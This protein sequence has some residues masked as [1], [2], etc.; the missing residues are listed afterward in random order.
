LSLTVLQVGRR[1]RKN[2]L[3]FF[4]ET[5]DSRKIF[6]ILYLMNKKIKLV[7]STVSPSSTE[8]S[9]SFLFAD[10]EEGLEYAMMTA[11]SSEFAWAIYRG[12]ELID[13]HLN[14]V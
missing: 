8:Y 14:Y 1:R 11:E 12:D 3:I 5:L 7:L 6:P 10:T 4:P 9:F 2:F 13:T